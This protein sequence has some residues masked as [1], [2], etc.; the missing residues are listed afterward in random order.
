MEH[1]IHETALGK[2]HCGDS[3]SLLKGSLGKEI[4]GKV[5]LVLTSPPFPLNNKKSYGNRQGEAYKAWFSGLAQ[6]LSDLLA[7]DGSVVI[8]IGNSWVP[9]RPVQSL[10]PLESLIG[11]VENPDA[12]LR[13]CQQ[14]VCYNPTR[15]PSPAEWRHP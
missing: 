2:Y 9:G 7:G 8:E 1:V 13:L 11:F 14:F 15:L 4:K 5:Q 12:D 3:A 10:L 6:V